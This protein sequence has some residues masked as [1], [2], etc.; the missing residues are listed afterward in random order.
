M[1]IGSLVL[2]C[3]L[4]VPTALGLVALLVAYLVL[5]RSDPEHALRRTMGIGLLMLGGL[6]LCTGLLAFLVTLVASDP[7]IVKSHWAPNDM[8]TERYY[9]PRLGAGA[10]SLWL[11]L[12]GAIMG[13]GWFLFARRFSLRSLVIGVLLL[14]LVASIPH[15]TVHPQDARGVIEARIDRVLTGEEWATLERVLRKESLCEAVS[16]PT[17]KDLSCPVSEALKGVELQPQYRGDLESEGRVGV[18]LTLRFSQA[19]ESDQIDLLFNE[20][21]QQVRNAMPTDP[22]ETPP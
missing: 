4:L 16:E 17:R 12:P 1:L 8:G 19:L 20:L 3:G 14:A 10:L 18:R 6:I 2:V 22:A 11:F 15:L 7:T 21:T 5:R 9:S 13:C